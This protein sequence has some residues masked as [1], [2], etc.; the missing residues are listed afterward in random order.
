MGPGVGGL[1]KAAFWRR[2]QRLRVDLRARSSNINELSHKYHGRPYGTP[3]RSKLVVLRIAS[4]RQVIRT[5]SWPICAVA[6]RSHLRPSTWSRRRWIAP[7]MRTF[8]MSHKLP[9][10]GVPA[11]VA[12]RVLQ[13]PRYQGFAS[14]APEAAQGRSPGFNIRPQCRLGAA[15][16]P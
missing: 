7:K 6:L 14:T 5:P 10:S 3:I 13:R 2:R 16:F 8:S 15:T 12:Q 11:L 1:Q 9:A 4:L